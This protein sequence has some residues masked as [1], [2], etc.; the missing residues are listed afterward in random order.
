[1]DDLV[2][3]L[4]LTVVNAET[5]ELSLSHDEKLRQEVTLAEQGWQEKLKRLEYEANLARRRYELVDPENRLVAHTLE[6]EWNQRLVAL[7]KAKAVYEA[8]RPTTYELRSTLEQMQQVIAHLRDLWY[9]DSLSAQ[10]KKE[11]LRC[12][13]EHVFLERHDKVIRTQVSWYGGTISELDVPKYLFSSPHIYHRIR[14]MAL[15]HTDAEIADMLN[16]EGTKT[17]KGR[18]WTSRRVMD[19]RLSNAIPSGFT[20]NREL[21]VPDS[22]YIT[23]AEAAAQLGVSQSTVQKWYRSGL[24][25]GKQDSRQAP[26]WI[27]WTDDVMCRLNGGA[28]PVPRMVSVRSLCRSQGMRPD[29]VLAWAQANEHTIYRLRRGS[30][31]RFYILPHES[32]V[33]PQ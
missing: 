7:E 22:G 24:L 18:L 5:L 4:F 9:A 10:D 27:R 13:I 32:S 6:T 29:E 19:F 23:S 20:T 25:S 16:R 14:H 17:V 2:E 28:V 30:S 31:L 12:L 21:R 33:R 26:L 3:E 1:V 11:L 15:T 8:Q